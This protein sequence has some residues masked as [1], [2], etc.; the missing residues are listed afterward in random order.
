ME[1]SLEIDTTHIEE[2]IAPK[3]VEKTPYTWKPKESSVAERI[4]EDWK[5][6]MANMSKVVGR[7][8]KD[9][10]KKWMDYN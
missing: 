5:V 4:H 2:A 9:N 10:R 6:A 7:N 3:K 1:G 8:F